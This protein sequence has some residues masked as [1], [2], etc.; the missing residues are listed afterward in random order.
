MCCLA[1]RVQNC[2]HQNPQAAGLQPPDQRPPLDLVLHVGERVHGDL[3]LALPELFF[4]CL[5]LFFVF[6]NIYIYIM[7][8][9]T[10]NNTT[11]PL[12]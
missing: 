12:A 9:G 6:F 5:F 2:G 3:V 1:P 10:M 7:K 8:Q 4:V 11:L